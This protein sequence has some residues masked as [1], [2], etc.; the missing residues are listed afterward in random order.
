[1]LIVEA[2]VLRP[3]VGHFPIL[4]FE[5]F[6]SSASYFNWKY[7]MECRV[8]CAVCINANTR[9]EVS[10]K[11]ALCSIESDEFAGINLYVDVKKDAEFKKFRLNGG[12]ISKIFKNG[13]KVRLH[14][15]IPMESVVF[16]DPSSEEDLARFSAVLERV[17][18]RTITHGDL[19]QHA[20]KNI[21]FARQS[22]L[23]TP[24]NMNE[25]HQEQ[26]KRTTSVQL[27]TF[28]NKRRVLSSIM[29]AFSPHD[30]LRVN[31][32]SSSDDL[33][34]RTP[35]PTPPPIQKDDDSDLE[36]EDD[37]DFQ[38]PKVAIS[39]LGSRNII[40]NAPLPMYTPSLSQKPR[41]PL[42][43]LKP[44]GFYSNNVPHIQT[45][46]PVMSSPTF[47]LSKNYSF[48]AN[49]D[50]KKPSAVSEGFQNLGNTCY[51]NAVIQALF[52]IET[53]RNALFHSL[54]SV[55]DYEKSFHKLFST[56]F[57]QK[58]NSKVVSPTDLVEF[59]RKTT[60]RFERSTQEDADEFLRILL[61][62][63]QDEYNEN[64]ENSA[65]NT[66]NP[67]ADTFEFKIERK[68]EC[69]ECKNTCSNVSV[70]RDVAVFLGRT[71]KII[72]IDSTASLIS[73]FFSKSK[74][75]YACE[76]CP[77]TAAIIS[78]TMASAPKVLIMQLKRFDM[79]SNTYQT[80]KRKD[81]VD[82]RQQIS[83]EQFSDT[84]LKERMNVYAQ[85]KSKAGNAKPAPAFEVIDLTM[86]DDDEL[87]ETPAPPPPDKGI[88]SRYNLRCS[89]SHMGESPVAGHYICDVYDEELKQWKC[90]N[91]ETMKI[92]GDHHEFQQ[93]RKTTAYLLFYV[94][95]Q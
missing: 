40:S 55:L 12:N 90:Y 20:D 75:A 41:V 85:S 48:P 80:I 33:S 49:T 37:D 36:I 66:Y 15:S 52:N 31:R 47:S 60:K 73:S 8:V 84:K 3:F 92:I 50:D 93:R 65:D 91:D 64:I 72:G 14:I 24:S 18:N 38:T 95:E 11:N 76:K 94:Q 88:S 25:T 43:D 89:I 35:R 22:M 54:P 45:S 34:A 46:R 51:I 71:N 30:S 39:K 21:S 53:F 5:R 32:K 81:A 4:I 27:K 7:N 17:Q 23:I 77:G 69:V 44:S 79:D 16:S 28:S 62:R 13:Q 56:V 19:I 1:M 42:T 83:L 58:M 82:L 29:P 10:V 61:D 74:V 78:Q 70:Y 9:Q 87:D 59:I 6:V 2:G 63:L 57:K 86:S 26:L 68:V 67:I